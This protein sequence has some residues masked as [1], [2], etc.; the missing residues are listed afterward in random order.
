[1]AKDHGKQIK[2]DDTYEELRK[3]GA[4]KEKAARI[5]N[6]QANPH[7]HPSEKGGRAAKYEDRSKDELYQKAKDIGIKGRSGMNKSELINALRNH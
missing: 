4:S 1:M 7:R 3:K 6:A 5:A 2:K